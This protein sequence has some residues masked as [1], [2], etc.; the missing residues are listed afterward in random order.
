MKFSIGKRK[1]SIDNILM[2]LLFLGSICLV[3]INNTLYKV[4]IVIYILFFLFQAI[5]RIEK[6]SIATYGRWYSAFFIW[7]VLSSLWVYTQVNIEMLI[8]IA[9]ATMATISLPYYITSKKDIV[10]I[11]KIIVIST[12][13]LAVYIVSVVG[14]E[15]ISSERLNVDVINSNRFGI[16]LAYASGFC[17]YLTD[18][19]DKRYLLLLIPFFLLI[20]IS[21]SKSGIL[22]FAI[23]IGV[24]Y[25]AS[26][27]ISFITILKSLVIISIVLFAIIWILKN[28]SWAY[29]ILG[30]RL[31]D[32]FNVLFNNATS[33]TGRSTTVREDM[34]GIGWN[35]FKKSPL[36]GYG[37]DNFKYIYGSLRGEI[38]YAH[39]TYIEVL[40]DTGIIGFILYFYPRLHVGLKIIRKKEIFKEKE[41]ILA[42]TLLCGMLFADVVS[43]S[44]NMIYEQC[45][46]TLICCIIYGKI[47]GKHEW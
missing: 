27:K 15:N 47:C 31:F 6:I 18:K 39:N 25:V 11:A 40:V 35:Y 7:T 33:V 2:I 16:N 34:I 42:L 14:L 17:L 37:L 41:I 38:T 19:E 5:Q 8:V 3:Y 28:V 9:M 32:F 29:E 43:V 23:I 45:L 1:F 21:G 20:I 46:M 24:Y 22:L 4:M 44:I 30:E 36:W 26:Q 10:V 12:I 13:I